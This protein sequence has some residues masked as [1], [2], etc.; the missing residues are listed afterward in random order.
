MPLTGEER[1]CRREV[2]R[3][4]PI[5]RLLHRPLLLLLGRC[6]LEG[7]LQDPL[8]YG[9]E[10]LP[11][12]PLRG[13]PASE[14]FAP[15][16]DVARSRGECAASL[17][18]VLDEAVAALPP[19]VPHRAPPRI[20]RIQLIL[21]R[22]GHRAGRRGGGAAGRA[23]LLVRSGPAGRCAG[24]LRPHSNGA[25]APPAPRWSAVGSACAL[26]CIPWRRRLRPPRPRPARTTP[27]R[28]SQSRRPAR[29]PASRLRRRGTPFDFTRRHGR[30]LGGFSCAARDGWPLPKARS[31][32]GSG[33]GAGDL[34]LGDRPPDPTC[35]SGCRRYS[36]SP[37]RHTAPVTR[38]VNDEVTRE[39][40]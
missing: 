23:P 16:D 11:P 38:V 25:G 4:L 7:V 17:D 33:F 39:T 29:P 6:V 3:S 28:V 18:V 31:G 21:P 19:G 36:S 32:F 40:Q 30:G 35:G 10:L 9:Q 5:L 24:V 26:R 12:E 14:V 1:P 20:D 37:G 34:G 8:L 22:L 15:D 2:D 27:S 13:D